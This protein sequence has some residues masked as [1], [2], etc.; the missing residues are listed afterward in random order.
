VFGICLGNQILGLALGGKTYKLKFGHHGG[1]H[2]VRYEPTGKIEITAHNHN[3]AV[4]PDSLRAADVELTHFDLNDG[5]LEGMRH[6]S[7]PIYSVQYHPEAAPGPHDSEY[8]FAD[9]VKLMAENRK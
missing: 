2:P 3:F 8:L 6:R 9:F 7:L 5:T 4:D 1:N